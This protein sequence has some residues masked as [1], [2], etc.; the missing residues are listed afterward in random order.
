M[1][2]T[3]LTNAVQKV[4][5]LLAG[6][7]IKHGYT[8]AG[9]VLNSETAV[10]L[11]VAVVIWYW[12][13]RGQTVEAILARADKVSASALVPAN[14]S[15]LGKTLGLVLFLLLP[16]LLVTGCS[17]VLNTPNGKI[18]SVTERGVGFHIVTSSAAANGTPNVD[19]GF[20]SSA[21]V[22]IPTSTN[23]VVSAPNFANKFDF[24]QS[25][26]LSL[27]IGEDIAS[28]NYQTLKAGATNS[29]VVIQPV[30]PK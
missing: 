15:G 30:T 22:I 16:V 12:S 23:T 14:T 11:V 25:G 1:N 9:T 13:H 21:V 5:V 18:L 2:Q 4:L 20:W 6:V 10:S 27:G 24:A 19:F 8:T 26:P 3:Q 29:A 28:G 7:A 17:T